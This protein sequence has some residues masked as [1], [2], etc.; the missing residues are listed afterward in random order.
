MESMEDLLL[1]S[2]MGLKDLQISGT[3]NEEEKLD[4]NQGQEESRIY[5]PTPDCF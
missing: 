4:V 3:Y 1:L 5:T 2:Q